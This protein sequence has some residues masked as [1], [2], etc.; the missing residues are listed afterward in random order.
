MTEPMTTFKLR[1]EMSKETENVV[2]RLHRHCKIGRVVKKFQI[3][4]G[5]W[6]APK[7]LLPGAIKLPSAG[8]YVHTTSSGD[9]P[10]VPAH[11]VMM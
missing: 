2:N 3:H 11:G 10:L 6:V 9:V 5:Q 8:G 4:G 7:S 1:D